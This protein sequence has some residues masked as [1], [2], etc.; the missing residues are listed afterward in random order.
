MGKERDKSRMGLGRGREIQ[1]SE[2]LHE[3]FPHMQIT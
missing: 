2:A 3:V 1:P